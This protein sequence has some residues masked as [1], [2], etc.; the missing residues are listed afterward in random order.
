MKLSGKK[1]SRAI[2]L[3]SSLMC[4]SIPAVQGEATPNNITTDMTLTKDTTLPEQSRITLENDGSGDK[5]LS[6]KGGHTL[7][8]QGRL[9]P[10]NQGYNTKLLSNHTL[11]NKPNDRNKHKKLNTTIDNQ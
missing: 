6:I 4:I 1:L 5:T 10:E 8:F 3:F 11:E 7:T 9:K 2:V